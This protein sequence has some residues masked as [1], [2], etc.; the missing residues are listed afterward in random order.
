MTV[1]PNALPWLLLS[2]LVIALD[3]LTKLIALARAGTAV[4]SHASS[5]RVSSTGRS[6]STPAPHSASSPARTV[7]SAGCSPRSRSASA[8]CSRSGSRARRA[9]T[10]ATRCRSRSIIGGA[11]GNLID[12]L[13]LG[14]V[15][16]F[17]HVHYQQWYYPAFNIADSAICV[18]AVLLIVFGLASR[19]A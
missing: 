16:D 17:I 3:Q 7:G 18:G 1:K 9:A 11:F 5:S 2:L 13:R 15:I 12:R 8:R 10:G 6:R 4:G 19:K 14:H